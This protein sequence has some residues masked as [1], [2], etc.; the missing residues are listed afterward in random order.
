MKEEK[1]IFQVGDSLGLLKV[2][3]FLKIMHK[4]REQNVWFCNDKKISRILK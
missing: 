4:N 2:F 1:K 3:Q